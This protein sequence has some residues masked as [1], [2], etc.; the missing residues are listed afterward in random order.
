MSIIEQR[1]SLRFYQGDIE[2]YEVEK[3]ALPFK[4]SFYQT[5][6]AYNLLNVLMYPGMENE[7]IRFIRESREIPYDLL[8]DLGEIF[9]IYK[10][11]FTLMCENVKHND[12]KTLHLYRVERMQA[13]EMI[14][15]GHTYSFTSCS[16]ENTPTPYFKKKDGILLLEW[17]I[18]LCTPHVSIN[19]ILGNNKYQYQKEILLPPFIH[20]TSEKVNFTPVELEYRDLNNQPPEAKFF[21]NVLDDWKYSDKSQCNVSLEKLIDG[22]NQI[23]TI[24]HKLKTEKTVTKNDEKYYCTWKKQFQSQVKIIFDEIYHEVLCDKRNGTLES[25]QN[26]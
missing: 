13:M 11:I 14:K 20:F 9:K 8:D 3:N 21:L 15:A 18:P 23:K 2:H 5:K 25:D 24:L 16:L 4:H 10:N 6:R 17:S 19:E 7:Y 1:N 12:T 26:E 22:C